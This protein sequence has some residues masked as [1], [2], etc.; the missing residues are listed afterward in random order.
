MWPDVRQKLIYINIIY[1]NLSGKKI[2]F[3]LQAVWNFADNSVSTE[4]ECI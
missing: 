1:I 2:G 3:L 4:R